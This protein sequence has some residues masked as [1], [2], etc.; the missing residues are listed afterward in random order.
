MQKLAPRSQAHKQ[1][2][3]L[4][5][6]REGMRSGIGIPVY[7]AAWAATSSGIIQAADGDGLGLFRRLI[8][9]RRLAALCHVPHA[10][11]LPE[12]QTVFPNS[13]YIVAEKNFCPTI[14]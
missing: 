13:G 11:L 10:C 14:F 7:I 12:W 6:G 2:G 9:L 3:R 1:E 5:T 4:T 8:G